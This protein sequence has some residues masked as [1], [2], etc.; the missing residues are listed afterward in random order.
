MLKKE[1]KPQQ[2]GKA[3]RLMRS[4]DNLAKRIANYQKYFKYQTPFS[5]K[6]LDYIPG[7][8]GNFMFLGMLLIWYIIWRICSNWRK[9]WLT[10][11]IL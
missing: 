4:I 1:K 5:K 3:V 11:S 6:K 2:Q 9:N 7:I 10:S 8:L